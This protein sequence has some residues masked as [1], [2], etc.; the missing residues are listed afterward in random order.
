MQMLDQDHFDQSL[1]LSIRTMQFVSLVMNNF[2]LETHTVPT[3]CLCVLLELFLLHKEMMG[4]QSIQL[5][6]TSP[7][8]LSHSFR[9]D[10]AVI[11]AFGFTT[12][13]YAAGWVMG[14]SN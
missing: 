11:I 8:L 9:S 6:K 14:G 13:V 1:T 4:Y 7:L 12:V 5:V 10:S 3:H 2:Y